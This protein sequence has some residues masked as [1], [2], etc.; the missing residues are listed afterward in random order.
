ME[1]SV[2]VRKN[3]KY[4]GLYKIN[5]LSSKRLYFIY[6]L[7]LL[8]FVREIKKI[9]RYLKQK[10]KNITYACLILFTVYKTI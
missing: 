8:V 9:D 4:L 1:P 2:N 10:E 5:I 7:S 3:N 6:L